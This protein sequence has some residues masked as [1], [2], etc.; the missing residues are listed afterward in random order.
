M[1]YFS[2]NIVEGVAENWVEAE[3]SWV[4]VETSGVEVGERF[5]KYP[6]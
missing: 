1:Q 2:L 6:S 3:M 5:S 4:E